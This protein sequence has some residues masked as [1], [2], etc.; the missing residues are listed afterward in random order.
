MRATTIH[1]QSATIRAI[2]A[3]AI[4]GVC[5]LV[6]P[7]A[8]AQKGTATE[9]ALAQS[10]FDEARIAM[11]EGNYAEACP[12]LAK[13]Q[14]L[15]PS[16]GTLLNLAVCHQNEG[17]TASAWVEFNDALSQ[18]IKDNRAD[19]QALARKGIDELRNK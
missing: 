10:L 13:S 2:A 12:K 3:V 8:F 6:T 17:K 14:K 9:R 19:R 11:K 5:L 16:G 7:A 1:A 18:A 4:G 15:D